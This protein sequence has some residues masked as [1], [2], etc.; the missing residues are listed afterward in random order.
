MIDQ[1]WEYWVTWLPIGTRPFDLQAWLDECGANGWE[2]VSY[3]R[4]DQTDD[5]LGEAIFKKVYV[6]A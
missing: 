3:T 6:Y 5:G 2:L 1:Q 4:R